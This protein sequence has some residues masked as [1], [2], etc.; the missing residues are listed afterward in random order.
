MVLLW[1]MLFMVFQLVDIVLL[2]LSQGKFPGLSQ[3]TTFI[4]FLIASWLFTLS[5]G[6]ILHFCVSD[7]VKCGICGCLTTLSTIIYCCIYSFKTT[8]LYMW[9]ICW[10]FF[11]KLIISYI[12]TLCNGFKKYFYC[13]Y[14]SIQNLL[15]YTVISNTYY[16]FFF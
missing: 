6:F 11:F 15:K 3:P 2:Y 12:C 13:I 4:S 9:D 8:S 10:C 16:F 14:L 7:L 5:L 1:S